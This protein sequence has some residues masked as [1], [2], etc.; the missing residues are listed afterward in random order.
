MAAKEAGYVSATGNVG[1]A[2]SSHVNTPQK[3]SGKGYARHH[4]PG[5]EGYPCPERQCLHVSHGKGIETVKFN[6]GEG[7]N[8][9]YSWVGK[10]EV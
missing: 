1:T 2:L 8:V 6:G 5:L 10:M 3:H 9:D 7:I 4:H